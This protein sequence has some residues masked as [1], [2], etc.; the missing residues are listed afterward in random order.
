MSEPGSTPSFRLSTP[1]PSAPPSLGGIELTGTLGF[2]DI[3][4]GCAY[5]E[6]NGT[7]YQVIYPDGWQLHR[8]P[9]Q[10]ISPAGDVV[11]GPG[12]P[13]TVRGDEAGDMA[14][15]CQIGPIFRATEVVTP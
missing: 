11:A 7:R 10:L 5:L 3:E 9:L 4:G 12:D 15:I 6:S 1:K 8:S 13:V 14:S 2:D